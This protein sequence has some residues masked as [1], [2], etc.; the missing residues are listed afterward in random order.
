MA[1]ALEA[2]GCDAL[3]AAG[4]EALEATGCEVVEAKSSQELNITSTLNRSNKKAHRTRIDIYYRSV[5]WASL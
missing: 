5:P 2:T 3:E 1:E 4:T